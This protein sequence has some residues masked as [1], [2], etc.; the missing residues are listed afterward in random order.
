MGHVDSAVKHDGS[1]EASSSRVFGRA[2]KAAPGGEAE[3]LRHSAASAVLAPCATLAA[4]L[5]PMAL[6]TEMG[7]GPKFNESSNNSQVLHSP[8]G[9][10][11]HSP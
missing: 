4:V 11:N 2:S 8:K 5:S 6:G 3:G 9:L 1:E 10:G 7:V